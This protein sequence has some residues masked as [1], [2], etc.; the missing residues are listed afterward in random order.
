[1]C[2]YVLE[3]TVA[4]SGAAR[5]DDDPRL[6]PTGTSFLFHLFQKRFRNISE[7]S[8]KCFWN[9]T[10]KLQGFFGNISGTFQKGSRA[11]GARSARF[12]QIHLSLRSNRKSV[13]KQSQSLLFVTN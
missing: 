7:T 3:Y 8:Q 13:Q 2:V 10:E 1:M 5:G 9:V 6:G 11:D 4:T 12:I